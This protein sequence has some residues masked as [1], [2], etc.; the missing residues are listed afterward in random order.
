[1]SQRALGIAAGLDPSVASTRMNRYEVGVHAPAYS[2]SCR[3][4]EVLEVPVAYLYCDD[5]ELAEF[6][7]SFHRAGTKVRREVKKL[8]GS[9]G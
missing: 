2:I 8:L 1:M 6:I 9:A 7:L 5:D 3:L 4:A